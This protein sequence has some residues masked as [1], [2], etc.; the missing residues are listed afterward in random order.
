[1]FKL[2]KIDGNFKPTFTYKKE[3]KSI[4]E[5]FSY[6]YDK[7]NDKLDYLIINTKTKRKY[8]VLFNKK[9]RYLGAIDRETEREI[10]WK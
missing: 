2:I 6:L 5:V 9:Y 3:F 1:M 4:Q 10:K 8:E 7:C